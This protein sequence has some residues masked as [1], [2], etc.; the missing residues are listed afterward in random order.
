MKLTQMAVKN[1]KPKDKDYKLTD[2]RGMYL[3]VSK[4]GQL[5]WRMN[6]RFSGKQKTLAL[7]VYPE[8]SLADAR[9]KCAEARETLAQGR[10]PGHER[11][12][13]KLTSGI[14]N[15]NTLRAIAE[16]LIVKMER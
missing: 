4:K 9:H 14:A 15:G 7:G 16:E 2:G 12:I 6:Y 5:Y 1:A 8:V 10:D 13:A 11:K 3:L